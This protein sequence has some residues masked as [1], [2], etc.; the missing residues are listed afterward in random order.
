MCLDQW[1]GDYG[2]NAKNLALAAKYGLNDSIF[3]KHVWQRWGYDYR[4][5][6][7][8]PPAGNQSKFEAMRKACKDA[9][10]LFCLHD[11][12]TDIYPDCEG[13]SYNLTVFNLDSTP[14]LAWFNPYRYAQ[15]YRW[16]PHAFHPW[17]LRNAKLLKK[18]F[19]P[20]AIFIDV[21]TAHC[22][23]DYLDREG[24]FHSK[25]ETSKNWGRAFD[26]YR[27]GFERTNTVC[28]S[29]A[30]QD[31]LIGTVDGAQS[32]HFQAEKI[33]GNKSN[34]ADSE[35]TPWHDIVSH[36]YFV[37]F[38]GGLGGRYQEERWH[39]GGNADLH[40]YGSDDYLSNT[41]IGGRNPMSDGP[42]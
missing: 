7:I 34:F 11:N 42:F 25:N 26:V 5:P 2:E 21:L 31:H 3:V 15:S 12:Y 17:C 27:E 1:E 20:E 39:E 14:Q 22:P 6:E 16:A 29:E 38:A 40:G 4:L 9:G 36:G 35:R 32:D 10:I 18:A 37:L 41:I 19:D 30:G 13:F 33:L 8:F 24:Q 28:I 23:F